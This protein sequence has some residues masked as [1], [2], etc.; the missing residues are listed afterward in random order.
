MHAWEFQALNSF[1]EKDGW[2]KF[3]SVQNCYSFLNR[4]EERESCIPIVRMPASAPSRR[5]SCEVGSP[6]QALR[7]T[8]HRAQKTLAKTKGCSMA[9]VSIAWCLKTGPSYKVF[10]H[11]SSGTDGYTDY[12]GFLRRFVN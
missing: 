3:I 6:I 10:K 4:E 11:W 5:Y 9:Q 2:L 12:D 8:A 7:G 1:A